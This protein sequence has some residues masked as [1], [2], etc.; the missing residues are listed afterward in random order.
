MRVMWISGKRYGISVLPPI[1]YI[2]GVLSG[3]ILLLQWAVLRR[4]QKAE[5]LWEK[6]DG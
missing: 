5:I 4:I 1:A 3:S 6:E 2:L